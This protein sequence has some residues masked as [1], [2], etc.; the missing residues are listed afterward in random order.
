MTYRTSQQTTQPDVRWGA[1]DQG[2][3]RLGLLDQDRTGVTF[4]QLQLPVGAR[5]DLGE[6]RG[7]AVSVRVV[8][9]VQRQHTLV[10]RS[11]AEWPA[12]GVY[13]PQS[14]TGE[15]GVIGGPAQ[16]RLPAGESSRPTTISSVMRKSF[17][18]WSDHGA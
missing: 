12:Q 6:K 13:G 9:L 2:P 1:D 10:P 8:D 7:D 11:G 4:D 5:L 17:S 14:P 15:A 3:S 18:S 16:R